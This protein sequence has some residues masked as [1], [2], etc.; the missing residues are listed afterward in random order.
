M[1]CATII[2][3][4]MSSSDNSDNKA[5]DVNQTDVKD[6]VQDLPD[7]YVG[8]TQA[9]LIEARCQLPMWL[10]IEVTGACNKIVEQRAILD[11]MWVLYEEAREEFKNLDAPN[12]GDRTALI[13]KDKCMSL[14]MCVQMVVLENIAYEALEWKSECEDEDEVDACS[15]LVTIVLADME[16]NKTR[17]GKLLPMIHNHD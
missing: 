2:T 16:L 8:I 6:A 9:W 1:L 14:R 15:Q 4:V 3:Q 11:E 13:H 17:T 12:A 5:G 7:A 10:R